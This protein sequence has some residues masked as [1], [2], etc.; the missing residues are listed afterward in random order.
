LSSISVYS[1]VA[2]I[3]KQQKKEE[4]LE[5]TLERIGS[6]SSEMISEMNDIVWAIN[7]RNDSMGTMLQRMDSYARPLLQAKN[8]SFEF[9]YD[10]DIGELNLE[11]EQRKNFYLIFKESVNNA[12]KYSGAGNIWVDVRVDRR[13]LEM[14]VRDDGKGFESAKLKSE[15]GKSLSGNGLANMRRRASDMKGV[16]NILSSPESGTTVKLVFPLT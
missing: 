7:P 3:Y 9:Q 11:M 6:A 12:L 1:Q 13:K 15:A 14:E 16:C 4:G 5:D 2:K 10:P 8:I